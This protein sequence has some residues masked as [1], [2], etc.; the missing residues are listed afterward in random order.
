[1]RIVNDKGAIIN[2]I[3]SKFDDDS[4]EYVKI[5]DR[6]EAVKYAVNE[7]KDG[8]I[9]L[10]AGKG[11]EDYQLICGKKVPFSEREII[12]SE[13]NKILEENKISI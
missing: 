12:V 4:C 9:V 1:M 10:F 11:H 7:A 3:A 2:E 8:D 13:A 6:V 5:A